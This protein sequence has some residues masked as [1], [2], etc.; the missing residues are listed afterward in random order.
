[1]L[2][3][4]MIMK[5]K[6]EF[7]DPYFMGSGTSR[8]DGLEVTYPVAEPEMIKHSSDLVRRYAEEYFADHSYEEISDPGNPEVK[9]V[10]DL[11][12]KTSGFSKHDIEKFGLGIFPLLVNYDRN[13][14]RE[15]VTRALNTSR[16][17]ETVH[18][19]LKR[20]GRSNPFRGWR[21]PRLLTHFISGNVVGYTSVLSRIGLPVRSNG[22]AQI[23]KL[24]SAS[25]FF[26]MIYLDKLEKMDPDLRKTI[27]CGYWAGGDERIEKVIIEESDAINILS[28]DATIKDLSIRIRKQNPGM[29]KLLHGHKIGIAFISKEFLEESSGMDQALDGLVFDI[30]AFDGG[31]CYNV[32]NIY[33]QGDAAK[34]A[35]KLHAKLDDF[36]KNI[37]PVSEIAKPTGNDLYN[38]FLGCK[39]VLSSA[40][41]NAFV[42][43]KRDP[44]F[45]KPDMLHRYVQ[46]MPVKDE[47]EVSDIIKDYRSYLQ[48]AIVAIPDN[49]IIPVLERFGSSGISNIHYPGSAPLFHVYEEPHD[50]EFDFIKIRYNYSARF[51][52]SNF[53]KNSDWLKI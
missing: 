33:V 19:Y 50:G 10:V 43:V 21:E 23:L 40:T 20:F 15:F 18:G 53:K 2:K 12:H 26:P 29:K 11:T 42:R 16:V 6:I 17:I 49:K 45:W 22:A 3:P 41:R 13:K 32:K 39:D 38:I 4:F 24:P 48:T 34:F 35:V 37:S 30:S 36:A 5:T 52:A 44:E 27:A 47:N 1:M 51:A 9:E 31:A 46:V 7:K 28:S 14:R 25:A 8:T